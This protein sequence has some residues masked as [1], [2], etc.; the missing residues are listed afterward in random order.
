MAE[1]LELSAEDTEALASPFL[2]ELIKQ[3]RAQDM[4]GAWE[5]KSDAQLLEPYILSAE[6]RRALPIM[7]DPDPE[8]LWRI[9]LF[10]N[11]VGLSIERATK[12]MVTPMMKMSHEG[13]GRMV[14]IAGRLIAVN[15]QLRD[16][17]RFGFPTY[18]KLAE[19]GQKFVDEGVGMV[20]KYNE[21]ANWG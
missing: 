13:F 2:S 14:L 19:A 10:Y 15:K 21:V 5:G 1:T 7:G 8:T 16:A 18:A 12:V 4:H 17:H 11:A 20:N 9:E 6:A 3:Y